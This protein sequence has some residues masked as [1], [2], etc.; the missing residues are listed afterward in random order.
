MGPTAKKQTTRQL[1]EVSTSP[2]I[3]TIDNFIDPAACK[4]VQDNAAGCFDLMFPETVSDLLFDGQECE[5]DGLL[6]NKA[7]SQEHSTISI[8]DQPHYPDGLHMDTNNKCMFRHVTCL[9]YLNDIP[10]ECGGATVFPLARCLPKD[11]ALQAARRLLGHNLSHTRSREI[12]S[13][14]LQEE[15]RLLE[16]RHGTNFPK[17]PTTDTAISIQPQ[18]G[19]LLVFFSRDSQG[20]EDPRSWHAGARIHH[21]N[22]PSSSSKNGVAAVTTKRILTLFKEVDCAATTAGSTTTNSHPR[23]NTQHTACT[24]EDYLAP[25]IADQRDWLQAKVKLQNALLTSY[26]PES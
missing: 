16:A 8:T 1:I 6:F 13:L 14:G 17:Q 26:L 22:A 18:A 5:M 4:R 9:L 3:F 20:R 24:L 12:V 23:S 21:H 2:L 19:K 11:P 7:D 15:A 10:E 25:Q